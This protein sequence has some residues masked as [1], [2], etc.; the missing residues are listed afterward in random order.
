MRKL[1]A[2]FIKGSLANRYSRQII[3]RDLKV[4][5]KEAV[6]KRVRKLLI[7]TVI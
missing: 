2:R 3:E 4:I 5:Y 1:L 7:E 6:I